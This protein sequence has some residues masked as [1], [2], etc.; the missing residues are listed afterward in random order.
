MP[1]TGTGIKGR[2]D[3]DYTAA[4]RRRPLIGWSIDAAATGDGTVKYWPVLLSATCVA[5]NIPGMMHGNPFSLVAGGFCIFGLM[6]TLFLAWLT[7][8]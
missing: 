7:H 3:Y 6:A 1:R 5:I 2:Q 4:I 8:E